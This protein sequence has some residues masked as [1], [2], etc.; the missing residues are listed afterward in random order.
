[1][2]DL[3]NLMCNRIS[4][5][6]RLRNKT[7]NYNYQ[8]TPVGMVILGLAAPKVPFPSLDLTLP[9]SFRFGG[10]GWHA[11]KFILWVEHLG[12]HACLCSIFSKHPGRKRK[13]CHSFLLPLF[14][15]CYER[16]RDQAAARRA[17][18]RVF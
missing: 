17:K 5:R 15:R 9:S 11:K 18:V 2:D 1:M 3:H 16:A 10:V 7:I 8:T 12:Y 4:L 6:S 13:R 14:L